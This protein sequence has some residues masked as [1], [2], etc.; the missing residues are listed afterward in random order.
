M[1]LVRA[2]GDKEMNY[3]WIV[4][5]QLSPCVQWVPTV[6]LAFSR[7]RARTLTTEWREKN[8]SDRFRVRKYVSTEK[9]KK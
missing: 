3:V 7:Q 5:M 1:R 9:A 6:S 4:E 2:A 8:P